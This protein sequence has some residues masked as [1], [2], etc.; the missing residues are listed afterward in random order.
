MSTTKINPDL[1]KERKT[2]TFDVQELTHLLDGGAEKTAERKS[3]G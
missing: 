2:C 3:R 1:V